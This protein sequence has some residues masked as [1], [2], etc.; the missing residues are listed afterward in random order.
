MYVGATAA[1]YPDG[2]SRVLDSKSDDATRDRFA[3]AAA[4]PDGLAEVL[5]A[6]ST[7][8]SYAAD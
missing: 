4:Y 6:S 5:N 1:K 2:L 3:A 7:T 8:S